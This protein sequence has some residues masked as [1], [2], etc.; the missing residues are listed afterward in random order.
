MPSLMPW[1]C[2][3]CGIEIHHSP[4][5]EM[6][7]PGHHYRCHVCRLELVI[8]VR[9]DRLTAL[10]LDDGDTPSPEQRRQTGS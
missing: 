7:R 8:D 4:V 9:T 10:T 1:R 6:P 3:A 2:P 5:E